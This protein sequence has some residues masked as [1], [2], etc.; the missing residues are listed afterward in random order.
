MNPLK[1]EGQQF[2][3]PEQELSH[4][5]EAAVKHAE[6][7]KERGEAVTHHEA[8]GAVVKS[9]AEAQPHE[10]LH[11]EYAMKDHEAEAITLE[12]SPEAHDRQLEEFIGILQEKGIKNAMS[13]A[14]TQSC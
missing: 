13:A 12:L 7:A 3:S 9:Y 8:V 10:V 14:S 5:R 6:A 4:L 1:F 11:P 2:T